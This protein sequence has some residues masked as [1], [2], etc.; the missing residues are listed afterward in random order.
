[1]QRSTAIIDANVLVSMT[2]TDLLIECAYRGLFAARWTDDIHREW[3]K[4]VR[5]MYPS[6]PSDKLERRRKAMDKSGRDAL[7]TDYQPLVPTLQLPDPSDRHVLAAAIH[8]ACDAIVTFDLKHFPADV[9]AAHG[10]APVH[11]DTFLLTAFTEQQPDVLASV[12]ACRARLKNPAKTAEV[13]LAQI[14]KAGAPLLAARLAPYKQ[15]I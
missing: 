14:A 8:G 12:K 5:Q 7:L 2:L 9:L 10:I 11:P 6:L 3:I 15:L 13:Y 1:M 4:A